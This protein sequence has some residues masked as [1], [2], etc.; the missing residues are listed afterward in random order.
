[1]AVVGY[2]Y[3]LRQMGGDPQIMGRSV[4][5]NG[6]PFQV[7]GVARDGFTGTDL[8][9]V[10]LW[11]PMH[12]GQAGQSEGWRTCRGCQ[13]LNVFVRLRPTVTEEIA[14]ADATRAYQQGHADHGEFEGKAVPHLRPITA[15][16]GST[17]G[18]VA[19]WLFGVTLMVLLIAC[20]NVG[21]IVLARGLVRGGET[22]VR[23]AL[24][25]SRRQLARQLAIESPVIARGG[26]RPR[27]CG[28]RESVDPSIPPS[29]SRVRPVTH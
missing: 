5:L 24:G 1:V 27:G 17:S 14:A 19:G 8:T 29:G 13:F 23:Q 22:A 21:N 20:A 4:L 25:V 16:E 2:R 3:W 26:A 10:D 15:Y 28:R 6:K 7:I 12:A 9:P 18:S 11:V